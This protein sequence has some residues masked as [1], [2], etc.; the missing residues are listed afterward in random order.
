MLPPTGVAWTVLREPE[1]VSDQDQTTDYRPDPEPRPGQTLSGNQHRPVPRTA[2]FTQMSAS[3]LGFPDREQ[4]QY[5]LPARASVHLSP[6]STRYHP[7]STYGVQ[8]HSIHSP[9]KCLPPPPRGIQLPTL[10]AM[11]LCPLCTAHAFTRSLHPSLPLAMYV[12]RL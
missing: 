10:L 12:D 11:S 2:A 3:S 4:T 6:L 8:F 1:P 7:L 9:H 5:S